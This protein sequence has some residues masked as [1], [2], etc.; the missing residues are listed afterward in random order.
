MT[1]NLVNLAVA[2]GTAMQVYAS[3]PPGP[4]PFPGLIVFQEAFGVNR[5]IR[6]VADPPYRL[7]GLTYAKN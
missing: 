5:H 6:A 3:H 1:G 7:K 2:D 4:G